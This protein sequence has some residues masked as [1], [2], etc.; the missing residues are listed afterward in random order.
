MVCAGNW[1]LI[2]NIDATITKTATLIPELFEEEVHIFKPMQ[3]QTQSV[4]KIAVE[5][6]N[7]SELPK[8]VCVWSSTPSC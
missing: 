8:M 1:V 3:F 5:P 4:M 2:E 7:P 6:L